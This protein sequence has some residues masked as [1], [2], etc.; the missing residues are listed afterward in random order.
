MG[1][2]LELFKST[3]QIRLFH[4]KIAYISIHTEQHKRNKTG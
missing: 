2:I 4:R 1:I 3:I